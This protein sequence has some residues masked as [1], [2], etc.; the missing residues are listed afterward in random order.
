MKLL[1]S[2]IFPNRSVVPAASCGMGKLR[3]GTGGGITIRGGDG[4]RST[5]LPC[6]F[7]DGMISAV[8]E[9]VQDL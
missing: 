8:S 3:P 5:Y 6:G 4:N 1:S 9:V 7:A 2:F